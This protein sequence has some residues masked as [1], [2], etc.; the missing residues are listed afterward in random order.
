MLENQRGLEVSGTSVRYK[1]CPKCD[2][3]NVTGVEFTREIDGARIF[4]CDICGQKRKLGHDESHAL[5]IDAEADNMQK[6]LENRERYR[7]EFDE[8]YRQEYAKGLEDLQNLPDPVSNFYQS[9][10]P[11]FEA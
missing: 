8:M 6:A 5:L 1:Q 3:Q 4:K 11:Q 9:E 2:R 7:R 10:N